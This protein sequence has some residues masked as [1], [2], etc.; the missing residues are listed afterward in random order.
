MRKLEVF[1]VVMYALAANELIKFAVSV[2]IHAI[3]K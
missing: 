1:S 3:K 2:V